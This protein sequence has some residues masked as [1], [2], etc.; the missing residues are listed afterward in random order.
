MIEST[1]PENHR[2]GY[3]ALIGK[4]N[5]G[6]ST[7]VNAL[8]G[9][10]ISIVSRK[11]QTTRHRVLGVL[12]EDDYQLILLDTPGVIEPKY[13]LQ[14][15]MMKSVAGAAQDADV[16]VFL[17][18]AT[19]EKV[20]T[21]SMKFLENRKVILGVNKMDLI[22]QEQALP[23]VQSYSEQAELEDVI[24]ISALNGKN[25]DTLVGSIVKQL[26]LGPPLYPADVISEHPERFF[27]AEI[28]REKIFQ[29]FRQEIPYSCQVN[30]VAFEEKEGEKDVIHAD[31]IIERESQ[32]GIL[33]GKKGA[34]LK[35]VG[36]AARKD[37]EEFLDRPVFL[38]LFVKVRSDW[39]NKDAFLK[40]YGYDNA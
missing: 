10:K 22:N 39:R 15:A 12:S 1:Y 23:L 20:D 13:G 40:S 32:K 35:K 29:Q 6:K 34:A 8:L 7:L 2:S 19:R 25:L 9:Q 27:V 33:I 17:V 16:I 18:D 37:I 30:V 24:P 28:V 31:I 21:H 11:P 14:Q 3:A 38:K 36:M 5:V 4:P 26:P